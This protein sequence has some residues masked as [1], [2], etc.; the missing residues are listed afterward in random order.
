MKHDIHQCLKEN[1]IAAI[2]DY[3]K[4]MDCTAFIMH[5]KGYTF[6]Y[7]TKE[8]AKDFALEIKQ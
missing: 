2:N 4:F 1:M 7:G 6:I 8:Q 5:D 3:L